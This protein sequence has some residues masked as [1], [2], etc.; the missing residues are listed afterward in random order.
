MVAVAL[1]LPGIAVGQQPS[2]TPDVVYGHKDGMALTYDVLH[3]E[4]TPNG[5]GALWMVSGGFEEHLR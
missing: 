5:A 3:P 2:V 1:T 4:G